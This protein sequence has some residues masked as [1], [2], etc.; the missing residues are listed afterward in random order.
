MVDA[1]LPV[2][3]F[4]LSVSLLR[5]PPLDLEPVLESLG[6]RE[7]SDSDSLEVMLNPG[8]CQ[9]LSRQLNRLGTGS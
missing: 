2:I 9:S 8:A 7:G 6:R 5:E 4:R 3:A 1:R